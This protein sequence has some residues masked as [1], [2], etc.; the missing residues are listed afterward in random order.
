MSESFSSDSG[1]SGTNKTTKTNDTEKTECCICMHDIPKKIIVRK[2]KC[3]CKRN[4]C[5]KCV[6][7]I[8]KCPWCRK[9]STM[10]DYKETVVPISSPI[11]E[12]SPPSYE[13]DWNRWC[14]DGKFWCHFITIIIIAG[15]IVACGFYGAYTHKAKKRE[16]IGDCKYIGST[17]LSSNTTGR[18][19]WLFQGRI[20]GTWNS[21]ES[22]VL[23]FYDEWLIVKKFPT[24]LFTSDLQGEVEKEKKF[25]ERFAMRVDEGNTESRNPI[26]DCYVDPNN[27]KNFRICAKET[28]ANS[29]GDYDRDCNERQYEWTLAAF[30]VTL[31][32]AFFTVIGCIFVVT[33]N[34]Q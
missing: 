27:Y 4:V 17:V 12:S 29:C 5:P 15:F 26:T 24:Y 10:T 32:I 18:N 2:F 13:I 20:S 28:T 19:K 30:I 9:L 23:N 8:K 33:G 7:K 1:T 21:G 25:R 3:K 22:F 34:C 14:G 6:P 16:N 11:S 31:V